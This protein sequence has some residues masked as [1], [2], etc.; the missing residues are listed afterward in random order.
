MRIT[1]I[2]SSRCFLSSL[3][4]LSS[5]PLGSNEFFLSSTQTGRQNSELM[6]KDGIF[7]LFSEHRSASSL[8]QLRL[9][10]LI[11]S[12]L[13]SQTHSECQFP[14]S[15]ASTFYLKTSRN[16][17]LT[18]E[19]RDKVCRLGR[20]TKEGAPKFHTNRLILV[21]EFQTKENV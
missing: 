5:Q 16:F 4:W 12:Y 14:Q 15:D 6:M 18:Q 1:I 21:Q 2:N 19:L 11:H 20:T 10:L 3:S 8:P 13:L 9:H 17:S 7:W